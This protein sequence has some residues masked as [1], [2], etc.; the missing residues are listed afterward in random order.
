MISPWL[1]WRKLEALVALVLDLAE[2]MPVGTEAG[3]VEVHGVGLAGDVHGQESTAA[4][5]L[6]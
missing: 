5:V 2:L 3:H 4:I 1:I 6:M